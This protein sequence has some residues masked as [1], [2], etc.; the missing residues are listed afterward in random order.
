MTFSSPDSL[1][2]PELPDA[3]DYRWVLLGAVAIGSSFRWLSHE[4]IVEGVWSAWS[5]RDAISIVGTL[6]RARD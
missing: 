3:V 6:D 1:A 4:E 5:R 2:R